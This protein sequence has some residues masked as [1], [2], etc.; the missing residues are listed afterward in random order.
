MKVILYTGSALIA[1][2]LNSILCRMALGGGEADAASFT[3]VRIVSGAVMLVIIAASIGKTKKVFKS[4]HWASAFFLFLYAIAFSFAYTGLTAG[5]GALILFG[6][7]QVT[8]IVVALSKGSHPTA[9]EWMGLAMAICGLVYLVLPGI[10][11]P[12]LYAS[13]LMGAA[14]FAWG[15]YTVLGKGSKEP[16]L[17][18]AGNFILAVPMIL[19]TA[20]PFWPQLHISGKGWILASLSGAVTSGVGYALWYAV[21]KHHTPTRTAVMQLSVPV[22]VAVLG[23][24][25]LGETATRRLVIAGLLIL[26][27]IAMTVVR[28]Q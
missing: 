8:I 6:S 23:V 17:I 27:G 28:K 14:G 24:L 11:S 10:A 15:A 22:I 7:V 20:L 21:L 16:L 26:G 3:I 1:F 2:A 5:T 12:P 19:I 9:L 25:T 18:T 13:L 4:G